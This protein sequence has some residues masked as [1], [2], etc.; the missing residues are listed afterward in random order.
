MAPTREQV[1]QKKLSR[2][3]KMLSRVHGPS[4][5]IDELFLKDS[6]L[7]DR[8]RDI[9]TRGGWPGLLTL[10][11]ETDVE[12]TCEF[13]AS[14]HYI[15]RRDHEGFTY[16]HR[17]VDHFTHMPQLREIFGWP[18]D[19]IWTVDNIEQTTTWRR[20][21]SGSG[22]KWEAS[23]SKAREIVDPA[24]FYL[25]KAFGGTLLARVSGVDKPTVLDLIILHAFEK[26]EAPDYGHLLCSFWKTRCNNGPI[27]RGGNSPIVCGGL[28][29]YIL[30]RLHGQPAMDSHRIIPPAF[31][32]RKEFKSMHAIT[33]HR[34]TNMIFWTYHPDERFRQEVPSK[35]RRRLDNPG[36]SQAQQPEPEPSQPQ[37]PGTVNTGA[38]GPDL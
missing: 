16:I 6:G 18:A 10:S 27:T 14:F 19:G 15:G 25:Q 20:L 31:M 13:L 9:L 1:R 17:G 23:K 35:R 33:V 29:T 28:I 36:P 22:E 24:Y 11:C 3:E 26:G 7:Y 12:D 2:A 4:T 21:T 37:P 5:F 38:G 8:V 32:K 34:S 30:R